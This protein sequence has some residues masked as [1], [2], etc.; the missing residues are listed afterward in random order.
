M[1]WRTLDEITKE[2]L[3]EL[4]ANEVH[5]DR[6]LEYKEELPGSGDEEKREFLADV[7]SF[8]NG[9][10]G[11]LLYGV[12]EKRDDTGVKLGVAAA[13]VGLEGLL[14]EPVRARLESAIR[15][16]IAPRIPGVSIRCIEGFERGPVV[17]VRV[18][19]SWTAPHMITFKGLSRFYARSGGG[20][21]VLDVHELRHAFL[22]NRTALAAAHEFRTERVGRL[23]AE[24]TPVRVRP[25][26]PRWLVH[27]VPGAM[28]ATPD[29]SILESRGND[30]APRPDYARGWNSRWTLDGY[31]S[32]DAPSAE[33]RGAAWYVQLFRSGCIELVDAL[34]PRDRL[35]AGSFEQSIFDFA[36]RAAQ[37]SDTL[38]VEGPWFLMATLCGAR[39]Q[40][41]L[42]DQRYHDVPFDL[43]KQ[44]RTFDRDIVPLPEVEIRPGEPLK[45]ALR[46]LCDAL[47]Q[48][49]GWPR[50]MHFDAAGS[51]KRPR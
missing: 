32:Y 8:A 2:S 17:L 51:W 49:S 34:L 23:L 18:P 16:G 28:D 48:A 13:V 35:W 36:R 44:S 41:L 46:P 47:W 9:A 29:M 26:T 38:G 25:G 31:V 27:L 11:D 7:S 4:A 20:K 33:E 14:F 3:L 15:D 12:R 19:R 1:R 22:S 24:E 21:H 30:L 5:E 42:V 43:D 39:G 40:P 50:S 45:V 6:H 10:G 37:A